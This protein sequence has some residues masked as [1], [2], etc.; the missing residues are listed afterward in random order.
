VFSFP[1]GLDI[2]GADEFVATRETPPQNI[3]IR[4]HLHPSVQVSILPD[5]QS[6]LLKLPNGEGWK[7]RSNGARL[8]IE[9]SYFC[10]LGIQ[11]NSKQLVLKAAISGPATE[12]KWAFQL[13]N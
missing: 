9:G 4:F 1:E 13:E 8:D 6:A 3:A 7:F 2:R 10:D 12:I 5:Q 11:R